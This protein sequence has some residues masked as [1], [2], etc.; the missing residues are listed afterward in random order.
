V[1]KWRQDYLYKIDINVWMFLGAAAGVIL[2]A[3]ITVSFQATRAALA[4]P[5][6]SLRSEG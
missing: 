2:I 4:N 1:L 3:L 6:T 5:V